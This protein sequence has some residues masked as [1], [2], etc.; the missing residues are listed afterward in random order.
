MTHDTH[1]PWRDAHQNNLRDAF[2]PIRR[3]PLALDLDVQRAI[4]LVTIV[5]QAVLLGRERHKRGGE[6]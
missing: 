3:L 2:A 6:Q 4:A 5:H 1:Q